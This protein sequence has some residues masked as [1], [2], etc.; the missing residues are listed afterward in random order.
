MGIH[1]PAPLASVVSNT[2]WMTVI[3][4]SWVAVVWGSGSG[5][6]VAVPVVSV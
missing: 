6:V 1:W 3:V 5:M 4:G 2:D